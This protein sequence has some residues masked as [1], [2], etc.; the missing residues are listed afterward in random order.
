[1]LALRFILRG[2]DPGSHMQPCLCVLAASKSMMFWQEVLKKRLARI[3][4]TATT[5]AV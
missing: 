4:R 5:R 2:E 1:M 3:L